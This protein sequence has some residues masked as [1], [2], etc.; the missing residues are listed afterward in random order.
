MTSYF[1]CGLDDGGQPCNPGTRDE[2][3]FSKLSETVRN[4]LIA[5]GKTVDRV[6]TTPAVTPQKFYDGTGFRQRCSS[7]ASRGTAPAPT[8]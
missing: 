6:Y 1:Q 7:R 8:C 5:A 4:G 2:R 3:T